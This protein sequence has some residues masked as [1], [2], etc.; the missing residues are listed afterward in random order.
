MPV[1]TL[2]DSKAISTAMTNG[3]CDI[4]YICFLDVKNKLDDLHKVMKS[5][6][7]RASFTQDLEIMAGVSVSTLEFLYGS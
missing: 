7:D 1:S 4:S 2:N 5:V 6:Q 3:S